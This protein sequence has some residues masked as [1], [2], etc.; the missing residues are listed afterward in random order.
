MVRPERRTIRPEIHKL[1]KSVWN[2]EELPE[3]WKES[4]IV[5]YLFIWRVIVVIVEACHFFVS[6]LENFI[7]HP[8]VKLN[9]ICRGNY[10][11]SLVLILTQQVNYWSYVLLSSNSWEKWEYTEEVQQL[12]ID[13]QKVS[14]S[15]RREILYNILTE[16]G[17]LMKMIRLIKMCLDEYYRGVWV[18]IICLICFLLRVIWGK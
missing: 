14:D 18:D 16:F 6:Y 10:W 9:S 3:D 1:I 11:G 4:I 12:V 15:F 7:Q 17:I 8:A 5:L 2:K 13:F